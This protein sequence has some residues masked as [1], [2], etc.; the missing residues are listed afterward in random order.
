MTLSAR[1]GGGDPDMNPTLRLALQKARSAN[2][3]KENIDRAIK[4]GTGELPGVKYEDFIY[5]GYGPGGVA[6]MMEV[7]TD[8]K[9]RTVPE[10]RHMMSKNGGNLGEPG[11]VS[12]MFEKKGTISILKKNF[13]EDSVLETALE[14]GADDFSSDNEYYIISTSPDS[15]SNVSSGLEKNGIKIDSGEINLEPQNK[16]NVSGADINILMKLLDLLEE[17]EDV[18]KIYSNFEIDDAELS[19]I[20]QSI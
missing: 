20:S 6:I 11:C 14:L 13:D 9:N 10:L 15:F 8:N 3:P 19:K 4:K 16:V 7:M 5:E 17:H 1:Q 12:W 18:Q 2:M